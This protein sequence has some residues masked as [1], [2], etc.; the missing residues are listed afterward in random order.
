MNLKT[1]LLLVGLSLL[2]GAVVRGR[3]PPPPQPL[4]IAL[5][6]DSTVC[7]YPASSPKRGWGQMLGEF[8]KPGVK[9]LDEAEG[10]AD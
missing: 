9:V 1:T 8:L 3:Q 5:I 4:R 7:D 6:G 10:A 2:P